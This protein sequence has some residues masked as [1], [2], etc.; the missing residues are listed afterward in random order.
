MVGLGPTIQPSARSDMRGTLDPRD[1]PEDDTVSSVG[2][3]LMGVLGRA[4]LERA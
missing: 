2:A 1:K 3:K 4:K